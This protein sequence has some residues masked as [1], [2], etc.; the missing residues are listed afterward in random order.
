MEG[1]TMDDTHRGAPFARASDQGKF[2]FLCPASLVG[3]G[4]LAAPPV[5][6]AR[7]TQI[8]ILSRGIAFG[9]FSFPVVG[10]YE[11]I[12]GY[13]TGEVSPSNPLN[14]VITDVALA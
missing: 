6:Q 9:G 5:A 12:I 1:G 2:V 11:Y 7:T 13:A 3:G 14:A 10:Q 4:V 8:I